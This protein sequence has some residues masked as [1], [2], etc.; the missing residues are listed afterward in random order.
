M[1][2]G[3]I[4]GKRCTHPTLALQ[5][6]LRR[7]SLL[8]SSACCRSASFLRQFNIEE[9]ARF[10][11]LTGNERPCHQDTR[12]TSAGVRACSRAKGQCHQAG[13][14]PS[15]APNSGCMVAKLW[16]GLESK[17]LRIP[18]LKPDISNLT[19]SSHVHRQA[20]HQQGSPGIQLL[21]SAFLGWGDRTEIAV[22]SLLVKKGSFWPQ[23]SI[24]RI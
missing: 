22:E 18:G 12:D 6:G 19:A 24:L 4:K 20:G 7:P 23:F 8:P 21:P 13:F 2:K 10:P 9:P 15:P 11:H 1:Q 5:L 17:L 14:L 16:A 3:S